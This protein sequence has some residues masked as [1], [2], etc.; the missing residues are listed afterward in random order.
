[1]VELKKSGGSLGMSIAVRE[2]LV[3]DWLGI[4][5]SNVVV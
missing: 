4:F 5:S 3:E 2:H 1:M